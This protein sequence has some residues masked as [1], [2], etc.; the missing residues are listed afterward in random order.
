MDGIKMTDN[1][2]LTQIKQERYRFATLIVITVLAGVSQGMLLPMLT[3]L[4]E[5]AGVTSGMNGLNSAALYAGVFASMFFIEKPLARF[6]YKRIIVGG[7]IAVMAASLLFPAWENLWFWVVLRILVG[8]GESSLHFCTQLW[9]ISSSRAERRGRNISFYGMSYAIG[10]SLGPVGL[11]LLRFGT[12]VPFAA[13]AACFALSLLLM[14]RLP[15]EYPEKDPSRASSD[16]RRYAR[17]IRLAWFAL[18]PSFLYGYMEATMN[19]SFPVYGLRMGWSEGWISVL[20]PAIGIG[21]LVLQMPLGVLSDRAG[22]K[23]VLIAA[24]FIGSLAFL[25]VPAAGDRLWVVHLLF[26]VA[27]GLVGSFF[28]LGLAY[29]ADLLPRPLL[30]SANVI[31]SLNFSIGSIAGP[32]AG[33]LGIQYLSLGSLFYFLGGFFLLFAFAGLFFKGRQEEGGEK[34]PVG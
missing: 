18:I 26:A 6:G 21:S 17:I 5:Q 20:L 29:L 23:P 32:N 3:V 16:G 24:A 25:M 34:Q 8:I 30:A 12:W 22:R 10:F 1:N 11:N 9:I 2:E 14:A 27:G 13:M 28:S 33:G 15:N 31:A 19:S 4:L 7:M